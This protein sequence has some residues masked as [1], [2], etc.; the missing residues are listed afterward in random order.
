[1][2]GCVK[3]AWFVCQGWQVCVSKDGGVCKACLVRLSGVASVCE[4][5]WRSV[6]IGLVRLSGVASVCE[7]G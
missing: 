6:Y 5:G 7:Q 1:M 2:E 4:Q 3:H